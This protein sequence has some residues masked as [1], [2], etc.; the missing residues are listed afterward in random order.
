M[1]EAYEMLKAEIGKFCFYSDTDFR[2]TMDV[3][4]E[5]SSPPNGFL[6]PVLTDHPYNTRR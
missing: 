1:N 2:D 4:E 3:Y 5:S 6:G